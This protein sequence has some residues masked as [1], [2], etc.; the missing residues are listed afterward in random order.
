MAG[1]ESLIKTFYCEKE[2]TSS[3]YYCIRNNKDDEVIWVDCSEEQLK[4]FID[5]LNE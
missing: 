3:G 5:A 2:D 1:K 4:L